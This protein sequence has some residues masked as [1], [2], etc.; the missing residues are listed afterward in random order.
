MKSYTKDQKYTVTIS[1]DDGIVKTLYFYVK[2]PR[3][4]PRKSPMKSPRKSP[5]KSPRK[6][7]RK[8]K[9]EPENKELYEKIKT[10][11]KKKFSIWPSL[12]AS[13]WLVTEYK[14]Q[15]GKYRIISN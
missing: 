14:N 7:P 2:S 9:S 8:F 6:S 10:Q 3:K 13:N 11:A 12:Y 4:S 1:N 5:M 15:G